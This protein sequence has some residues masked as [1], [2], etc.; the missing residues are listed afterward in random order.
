MD[1]KMFPEIGGEDGIWI[2]YQ[3]TAPM[4]FVPSWPEILQL[5]R[6]RLAE[7]WKNFRNWVKTKWSNIWHT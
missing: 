2:D 3:E 6:Q 1:I 5:V 7:D 4:A